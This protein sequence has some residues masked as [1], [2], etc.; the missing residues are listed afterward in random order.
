MGEYFWKTLIS[1]VVAYLTPKVLA[2]V[3]KTFEAD[4]PAESRRLPAGPWVLAGLVGG[5][6]GGALS[7]AMGAQGAGNWVVYGAALGIMQWFALRTYLPVGSWWAV[8]SALGWAVAGL[9]FPV[10]S[11]AALLGL[12]VGALQVIGLK[13]DGKAWWILGNLIAWTVV[14]WLGLIL[15]GPIAGALGFVMGWLVNWG[16]VG[17]LGHL[18]LLLPLSKLALQKDAD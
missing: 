2:N 15:G 17:F 7:G 4:V 12:V 9:G 3:G 11:G 16:L 8:A 13:V 14:A 18:F 1:A 6:V 10:L 5:L